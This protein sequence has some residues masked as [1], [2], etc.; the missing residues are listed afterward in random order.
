MVELVS[1]NI[2][3]RRIAH[4]EEHILFLRKDVLR[5]PVTWLGGRVLNPLSL[6]LLL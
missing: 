4:V 1:S 6:W 5:A 3:S 2:F